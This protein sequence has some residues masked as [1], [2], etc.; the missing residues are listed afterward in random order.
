[1]IVDKLEA[2]LKNLLNEAQEIYIAVAL[3]KESTLN[4]LLNEIPE[5]S[6]IKIIVGIDLP[7][8]AEVL[9]LLK[10]NMLV[11][12]KLQA[13]LY[14]NEVRTFHPKLYLAK[15][16]NS[17]SAFIGSSN[18]TDG[19]FSN[20]IELNYLVNDVDHCKD[21]I[22]WFNNIFNESFPIDEY[23]INEYK[24]DNRNSYPLT[25]NIKFKFKKKKS[26]PLENIDFSNR[27]FKFEHHWAFRKEIWLDN[28]LSAN[29]ERKGVEGRLLELH[30]MIYHA[31]KKNGLEILHSNTDGNIVSRHHQINELSPR[32]LNAMWLSYGKSQP[33]I[34][35]YQNYFSD[36]EQRDLQTFIHHSRLQI[37]I[38]LTTIG[39]WL[40][41]GKENKGSLFDRDYFKNNMNDLTYRN[42]FF[43]KLTCLPPEYWILVNDNKRLC[44]S[45]VSQEDLHA[46]CKQD[47][48]EKY[49]I[50]GRDYEI[51]NL[52]MSDSNLPTEVLTVFKLLMPL[53]KMMRHK[54]F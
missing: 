31:F 32:R 24:K 51:T 11:N 7:T 36:K 1:M 8:T 21:L 37:R 13:V 25:H 44:K 10:A 19:G 45:F 23:N 30:N 41:F 40:L 6:K 15:N 29:K 27:F 34:K 38:E 50:I 42:S 35:K 16:R 12:K 54:P 52:E 18:L 39:I 33:E 53:Y 47:N 49:F 22:T 26:N 4:K 28:S 43:N 46:F 5:N 14:H 48:I 17:W 2:P 9:E 20:N 3:L